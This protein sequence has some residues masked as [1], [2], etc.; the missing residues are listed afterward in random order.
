MRR[1]SFSEIF[2]KSHAKLIIMSSDCS[3]YLTK[4][5]SIINSFCIYIDTIII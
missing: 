4:K 1:K 3:L 5:N 2:E